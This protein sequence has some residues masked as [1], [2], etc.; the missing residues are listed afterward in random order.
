MQ[1]CR[2]DLCYTCNFG[3]GL[4]A[5]RDEYWLASSPPPAAVLMTPAT[6][7]AWIALVK[8]IEHTAVCCM[9]RPVPVPCTM[10][11]GRNVS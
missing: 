11:T 2:N 1:S 5:Q 6:A 10:P 9:L 3:W 8:P 7:T 4:E